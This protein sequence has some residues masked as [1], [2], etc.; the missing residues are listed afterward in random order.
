[1]DGLNQVFLFAEKNNASIDHMNG[2]NAS[3]FFSIFQRTGGNIASLGEVQRRSDF[4]LFIGLSS[5]SINSDIISGI[6]RNKSSSSKKKVFQCISE[7]NIKTKELSII[8]VPDGQL[9]KEV[10]NLSGVS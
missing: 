5:D 9:S 1:M 7:D 8:K 3:K 4:I 10:E 2:K 6:L